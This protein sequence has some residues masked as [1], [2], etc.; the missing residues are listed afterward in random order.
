MSDTSG[1]P[2]TFSTGDGRTVTHG[3]VDGI[4]LLCE[5]VPTS[6]S[7]SFGV[8]IIVGSRDEPESLS[9]L[10]HF[11]EHLVFKGT[12]GADARRI[13]VMIDALGGHIDAFTTREVTAYTGHVVAERLGVAFDLV[14]DLTLASTFPADEIERERNVILEEIRMVEDAPADY[15]HDQ[16]Y[17]SLWGAGPLGRAIT[18]APATVARIGRDDL[19]GARDASYRAGRIVISASGAVDFDRLAALVAKRF[20]GLSGEGAPRVP[21]AAGSSGGRRVVKKPIEQVHL[22]AAVPALSTTDPARHDLDILNTIFGGGVSSRLFQSVREERGLA[23]SVYSYYEEYVDAGFFAVYAACAPDRFRALLAA[24]DE[25]RLRLVADGPTDEE[26]AR[27]IRMECDNLKMSS[28]SLSSRM[29]DLADDWIYH[30]RL[31]PL[32]ESLA[33]LEGV[34]RESVRSLAARLLG[35]G[36]GTALAVGP[37]SKGDEDRLMNWG[38]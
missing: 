8:W 12:P 25:E 28:E 35:D 34:T 23:Y 3:D 22:V 20:G 29:Y 18:G 26:V 38:G 27:A 21:S 14:A 15:A 7:V 10:F 17:P 31:I 33:T 24:V 36:P 16:L 11:L 13:A 9:G 32:E 2:V 19:I 5:T 6:K 4:R 30:G 37:V 1:K